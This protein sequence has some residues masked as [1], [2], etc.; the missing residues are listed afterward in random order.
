MPSWVKPWLCLAALALGILLSI[1]PLFLLVQ[2]LLVNHP[3]V[4]GPIA[5]AMIGFL[6]VI[7]ATRQGFKNLIASQE[8]QARRDREAREA[9]ALRDQEAREQQEQLRKRA[10]AEEAQAARSTLASSLVGELSA[11]TNYVKRHSEMAALQKVVYDSFG[12]TKNPAAIHVHNILPRFD[13]V[14][15]KANVGNLGL[16]GPS[17][18]GDVVQVYQLFANVPHSEPIKDMQAN[19]IAMLFEGIR[20]TADDWILNSYHVQRRLLAQIGD[21]DDPGPLYNEILRRKA[22]VANSTQGESKA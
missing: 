12:T 4:V 1:R 21:F 11:A 19:V 8:E 22:E 14:I 20:I 5:A 13:P 7:V 16:L 18:A 17:T 9:Q 10:K 3:T 2:E 6:G 15:F